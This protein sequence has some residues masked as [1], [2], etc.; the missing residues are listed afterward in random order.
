[1]SKFVLEAQVTSVIDP[2]S[3]IFT[4]DENLDTTFGGG[5]VE[6]YFIVTAEP[7]DNRRVPMVGTDSASCPGRN[8]SPP[9]RRMGTVGHVPSC[10]FG[11]RMVPFLGR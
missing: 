7:T 2:F 10:R 9:Y 11:A 3:G 6:D 4:N 8:P 5:E 1:M